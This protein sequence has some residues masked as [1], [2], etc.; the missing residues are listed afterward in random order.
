MSAAAEKPAKGGMDRDAS[1]HAAKCATQRDGG[2]KSEP[3]AVAAIGSET[4]RR[5]EGVDNV[6]GNIDNE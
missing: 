6:P 5:R 2:D 3:P 4:G 1:E